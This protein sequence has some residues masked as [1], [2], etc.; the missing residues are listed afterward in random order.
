MSPDGADRVGEVQDSARETLLCK[1]CGLDRMSGRMAPADATD[2]S[3]NAYELKSTTKAGV[4]TARDV[5]LHTVENW[6]S[7][8]WVIAKGR[9][10]EAGFQM[11]ALYIAH[12]DD[13]SSWFSRVEDRLSEAWAR[14]EQVIQAALAAGVGD[15]VTTTVADICRRGI[16]INNPKIPIRVVEENA[17][18]LDHTT[19]SVAQ[20]QIKG[21]VAARPLRS[22]E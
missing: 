3:G 4:T 6:R 14:C 8:Y 2:A 5:G 9:N 22:G 11:D 13:L 19:P 21:F 7:K 20:A 18:P 12:P 16:T 15:E 1:H 17:T 10:M